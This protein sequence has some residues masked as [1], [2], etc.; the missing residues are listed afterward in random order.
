MTEPGPRGITVE[1]AAVLDLM[2]VVRV[3]AR[4]LTEALA[5]DDDLLQRVE[6]PLVEAVTNAVTHASHGDPRL[7]VRVEL[8]ADHGQ[9][10]ARVSDRGAPF[11]LPEL[12]PD[13]VP[14]LESD[15]GRGL[16]LMRHLTDELIVER[17]DG[18]N[19]VTLRW[20]LHRT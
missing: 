8:S 6:L 18:G 16:F 15:H 20:H 5:A 13:E 2:P 12:E 3:A 9:L 10:T 19:R 17:H 11:E 4:V 14:D 1:L 7:T